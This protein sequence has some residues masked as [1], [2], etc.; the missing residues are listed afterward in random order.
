VIAGRCLGVAAHNGDDMLGADVVG[1]FQTDLSALENDYKEVGV[2]NPPAAVGYGALN[3]QDYFLVKNSWGA[4]WG[5]QGFF[6]I[7][8]T[9]QDAGLLGTTGAMEGAHFLKVS[10]LSKS[11]AA[12][13]D[14]GSPAFSVDGALLDAGPSQ[15]GLVFSVITM[16]PQPQ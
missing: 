2:K 8:V 10:N 16:N 5:E 11:S 1:N 12:T 14:N 15:V 7:N 13:V 3:G 6:R 9:R 4:S